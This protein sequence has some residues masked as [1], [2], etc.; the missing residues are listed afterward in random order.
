MKNTMTRILILILATLTLLTATACGPDPDDDPGYILNQTNTDSPADEII[1]FYNGNIG[2]V[3][4]LADAMLDGKAYVAYNYTYR[5]TDYEA[6]TLE[7]YA[8]KQTKLNGNW[9]SCTDEDAVR[10]TKVKFA[11]TVLYN[12]SVTPNAVIF[13]PRTAAT[14]KTVALVY[15]TGERDLDMISRGVYHTGCTVTVTP[16]EGNWYCVEAVRKS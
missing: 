7:F 2:A 8:Q 1:A 10:L 16:I 15:C 11:G 14:D 5:M 9:T 13:S 3:T 12:P 6:G 4:V